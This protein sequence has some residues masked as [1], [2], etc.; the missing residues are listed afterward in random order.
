MRKRKSLDYKY[1][2][3]REPEYVKKIESSEDWCNLPIKTTLKAPHSKPDII[4][5]GKWK[6]I[7][8][9]IE[10]ACPSDVNIS[11]KNQEKLNNY[12]ALSRDMQIFY[13][14]YRFEFLPMIVRAFGYIPKRLFKYAEDI[15]FEKK[16]TKKHISK[17]QGILIS[18]TI[19]I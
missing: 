12:T 6:K 11:S 17:M 1:Q 8:T 16:E 18:G 15:G 9:I 5:R 19:K 4:I 14:D 7:C 13:R 10:F 3:S 2:E